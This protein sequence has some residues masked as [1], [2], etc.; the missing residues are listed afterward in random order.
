MYK[1]ESLG[2]KEQTVLKVIRNP[3]VTKDAS[4]PF[5]FLASIV[6]HGND[7]AVMYRGMQGGSIKTKDGWSL[8]VP[9]FSNEDDI[10]KFVEVILELNWDSS[11]WNKVL[12]GCMRS[13]GIAFVRCNTPPCKTQQSL[14]H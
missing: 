2:R 12:L 4:D 10:T 1:W 14:I 5:A 3:N 8:S 11:M 9:T 13:D 6:E 7:P